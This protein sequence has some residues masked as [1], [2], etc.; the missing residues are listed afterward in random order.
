VSEFRSL[1]PSTRGRKGRDPQAA[2][3]EPHEQR[4]TGCLGLSSLSLLVV[5]N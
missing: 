5:H 1:P 4:R 2:A 3:R